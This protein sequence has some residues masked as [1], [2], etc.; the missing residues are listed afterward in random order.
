MLDEICPE[1]K[2][3]AVNLETGW[4]SRGRRNGDA[5]PGEMEQ[6]L[7]IMG[8]MREAGGRST[9]IGW[10]DDTWRDPGE[11]GVE[12]AWGCERLFEEDGGL[13]DEGEGEGEVLE[14][15]ER[16]WVERDR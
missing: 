12:T 15:E 2:G 6:S 10:G 14:G 8:I 4:P 16:G 9:F 3:P 7:A 1:S 13:V 11:L 5:V